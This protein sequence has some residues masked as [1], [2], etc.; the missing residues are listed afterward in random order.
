MYVNIHFTDQIRS[1][2]LFNKDIQYKKHADSVPIFFLAVF[3][4]HCSFR[5]NNDFILR[6]SHDVINMFSLEKSLEVVAGD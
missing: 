2:S 5:N 1:N 6:V 4:L 3:G